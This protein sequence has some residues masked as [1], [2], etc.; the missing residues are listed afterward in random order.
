MTGARAAWLIVATVPLVVVGLAVAILVVA[1]RRARTGLRW[2][3]I[4]DPVARRWRTVTA[5]CWWVGVAVAVVAVVAIAAADDL[6]RGLMLGPVVLGLVLT[7]ATAVGEVITARTPGAVG[8]GDREVLLEVRTVR[9]LVPPGRLVLATAGVVTAVLTTLMASLVSRADDLGRAGRT[10]PY[11]RVDGS[12][13]ARGPWPGWFY[14][15]P[16]WVLLAILLVAVAGVLRLVVDRR[17]SGPS[18]R[19][20]FLDDLIRRTSAQRLVA[21]VAVVG[22]GT[23]ALTALCGLVGLGGA[24]D[25]ELLPGAGISLYAVGWVCLSLT[26]VTTVAGLVSLVQLIA[27]SLPDA[28]VPV[29]AEGQEAPAR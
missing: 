25:S 4:Q 8:A 23:A 17:R 9:G 14:T 29:P 1:L 6:G 16:V 26:L 20:R 11:D 15:V 10:I 27:P 21:L 24:S 18:D 2:S 5:T 12:L 19:E 13:G 3:Q 7:A 28:A 22:F